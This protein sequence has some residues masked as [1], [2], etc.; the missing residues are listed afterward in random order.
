[1][2]IFYIRITFFVDI[3]TKIV[4]RWEFVCLEKFQSVKSSLHRYSELFS[5]S[6]LC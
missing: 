5:I 3:T 1:M 2:K 6:N 4:F